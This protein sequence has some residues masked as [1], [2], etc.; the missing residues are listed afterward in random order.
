MKKLIFW[1]VLGQRNFVSRF[2]IK[3]THIHKDLI[4]KLCGPNQYFILPVKNISLFLQFIPLEMS[5]F[6][7]NKS[8][9]SLIHLTIFP[10]C[11]YLNY[12]F[13]LPSIYLNNC[14][15]FF[16]PFNTLKLSP[17]ISCHLILSMT[18]FVTQRE[19]V[20]SIKIWLLLPPSQIK[21]HFLP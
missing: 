15:S 2:M 6:I 12:H 17:K 7:F 1:D 4:L 18:Y 16:F 20:V 5:Y 21:S 3:M 13:S 14:T 19:Y 8:K 11:S 9:S 10:I